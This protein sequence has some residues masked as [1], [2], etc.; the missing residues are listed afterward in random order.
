MSSSANRATNRLAMLLARIGPPRFEA[1]I[2][3]PTSERAKA[4]PAPDAAIVGDHH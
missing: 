1:T 2:I 4:R 3:G